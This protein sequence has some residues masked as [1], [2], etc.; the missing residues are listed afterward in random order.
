MAIDDVTP[1]TPEQIEL[2]RQRAKAILDTSK[3][4]ED[5]LNLEEEYGKSLKEALGTQLKFATEAEKR[6]ALT[7][8]SLAMEERNLK[9]LEETQRLEGLRAD[10]SIT[11]TAEQTKRLDELGQIKTA[12]QGTH[13]SINDAID[14][15]RE[16]VN[17]T[18]EYGEE[19]EKTTE[20][21]GVA[22][23]RVKNQLEQVLGLK[24]T[25]EDLADVLIDS[26]AA[27][28]SF[29][30]ALEGVAA[31]YSEMIT[32]ANMAKA[33]KNNLKDVTA[34][35]KQQMFSMDGL[36]MRYEQLGENFAQST[37]LSKDYGVEIQSLT[38][39]M[40]DQNFTM[41]ETNQA[42]ETLA[43]TA[44]SF[45]ELGEEG[46]AMLTEQALQFSRL[47][48]SA[49][50]F[51]AAIDNLNKTFGDTPEE[52]NK[53]TEEMSNFA[54]AMGVGPNQ[55]L[56]D[57]NAQLPLL[58]RYG[59]EDGVEMFKELAATAKLAGVEMSDLVGIAKT[60]DTFEGAAEA[61]GKLNFML[62]GPLLN[63][64]ELINA[65]ESE[66]IQILKDSVRASG[67]AFADMDRFEKDLIAQTLNVDVS[68]AQKLFSDDNISSIE[69]ATAAIENKAGAM[70]SLAD[71]AADNT[72]L[73]QKE[74]AAQERG[75]KNMEQLGGVMKSFHETIIQ[76]KGVLAEYGPYLV[77]VEFGFKAITTAMAL[78]GKIGPAMAAM[79]VGGL[80]LVRTAMNSN[81]VVNA[82]INAILLKE[83]VVKKARYVADKTIALSTA[84]AK[85]AGEMIL[86]AQ[87]NAILIQDWIARKARYV[88]DKAMALGTAAAKTAANVASAAASAAAAAAT[89]AANV[90]SAAGSAAAW[91][92]GYAARGAAAIAS[93]VVILGQLA[94]QAAAS[95]VSAAAF[96]APWIIG[97]GVMI[98]GIAAT[99]L[100][101]LMSPIGLIIMGIVATIALLVIY[102]D[103][104]VAAFE[105]GI[106]WIVE[107]WTFLA[108]AFLWPLAPFLMIYEYWDKIVVAFNTGIDWI[109][110]NWTYLVAALFWP[111]APFLMI[112]EYWEE[113][114]DAFDTG[115][116]FLTGLFDG[117]L[118]GLVAFARTIATTIVDIIFAIPMGIAKA[119]DF[120][121]GKAADLA[122]YI[123]GVDLS[124]TNFAGDVQGW[125]ATVLG[126]I[127]FE[128]GVTNYEGGS[129]IVGEGG[130]EL[131]TLPKGSNVITN[132]NVNRLMGEGKAGGPAT[133]PIEQTLN[134]TLELDGDVL[135]RH[136]RKV[137]FDTMTQTMRFT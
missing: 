96:F 116:G 47:G 56:S 125:K 50:T 46:R 4:M 98:A 75:L 135:A 69:E 88:A 91:I 105:T 67:K 36:L 18:R 104:I 22:N 113:I 33:I 49:D 123:P 9:L 3:T 72:T 118:N 117:F 108:A 120:V 73:A 131:V 5:L 77:A 119:I 74:A 57:F 89:T 64:V 35:S 68:V 99:T 25:Q 53:T 97:F 133:T 110:E 134:I 63:S 102:W 12:L 27:G 7:S 30:E 112:Y 106:D 59:K 52:V 79:N 23:A 29:T 124:G 39:S 122:D 85:A 62:G 28:T 127:G 84:A 100:A 80:G 82:Q 43:V 44:K 114:V 81:L 42:Y 17:Q 55:M 38:L 130:P 37:G 16:L 86:I 101:F 11:L 48:V 70:G 107:N 1:L 15:Q 14:A 24:N 34:A 6:A 111:A 51:G 87:I 136:T 128:E 94:L 132:E 21:Q 137:A 65:N 54:R 31:A 109:L 2:E 26:F 8:Q 90:A 60:F 19:L 45:T 10:T 40:N 103:E 129:A 121:M 78:W 83:W 41:A 61:A 13:A 66:R 126:A 20:L 32:K 76:I 92:A 93:G 58:A 71:Q 95:I 115:V